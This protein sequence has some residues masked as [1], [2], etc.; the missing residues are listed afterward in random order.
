M[1]QLEFTLNYA[2]H[3]AFRNRKAISA[4]PVQFSIETRGVFSGFLAIFSF[5]FMLFNHRLSLAHLSD[6]LKYL[7]GFSF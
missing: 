2:T 6:L 1:S 4:D 7:L 5:S 3:R